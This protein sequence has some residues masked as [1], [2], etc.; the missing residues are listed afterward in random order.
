[1]SMILAETYI[2]R[3]TQKR[4]ITHR[5]EAQGN[6]C[7]PTSQAGFSGTQPQ[8]GATAPRYNVHHKACCHFCSGHGSSAFLTRAQLPPW[9]L[10]NFCSGTNRDSAPHRTRHTHTH[11]YT[12]TTCSD[13]EMN[14]V[15]AMPFMPGTSCRRAGSRA[16]NTQRC[17]K[18][19]CVVR[20]RRRH[21]QRG[22][23]ASR[24]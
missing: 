11:S 8:H 5:R 12:R 20:P 16:F 13:S 24:H 19:R 22:A 1:M 23:A 15:R 6:L 9:V 2:P 3:A 17:T 18:Q 14:G 10:C 21:P 4:A 7:C